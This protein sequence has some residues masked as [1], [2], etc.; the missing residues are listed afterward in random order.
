MNKP[1][2]YLMLGY[3]GAGKTTTAKVIH[4]LTGAAHLWADE[5]RRERYGRPDYSHSENIALYNHM[6]DLTAELLAA[7]N[8]VIF[9]TNFN[10]RKD[11][12]HLRSIAKEHGAI[13]KLIW[14]KTDRAIAKK[15]ATAGASEGDTRVLGD[16]PAAAFDL[17]SN[18]LEPPKEDEPYISIDGTKVSSEYV[19]E[20]LRS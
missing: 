4:E 7:G 16:M 15:R 12:E 10:F 19:S 9:D 14:V 17:V 3:P 13:T 18:K 20:Q 5:I 6:N 11:R 2:L 8:S 1:V